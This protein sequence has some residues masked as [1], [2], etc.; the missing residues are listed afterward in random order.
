MKTRFGPKVA[1]RKCQKHPSGRD[2]A[3]AFAKVACDRTLG[4]E[5]LFSGEPFLHEELHSRRNFGVKRLIGSAVM[6]FEPK[7]AP[8][9]LKRQPTKLP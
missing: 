7:N 9:L 2:R 5:K 8:A 4:L 3:A 6:N 1:R